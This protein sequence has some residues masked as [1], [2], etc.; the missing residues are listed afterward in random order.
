[1]YTSNY[2]EICFSVIGYNVISDS[3]IGY[4]SNSKLSVKLYHSKVQIYTQYRRLVHQH[5]QLQ[6][7]TAHIG[8]RPANRKLTK[9]CDLG[10]QCKK[11]RPTALTRRYTLCLCDVIFSSS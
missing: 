2:C 1:M 3:C 6:Y 5:L 10:K 4:S 11:S 8:R 9:K 7:D